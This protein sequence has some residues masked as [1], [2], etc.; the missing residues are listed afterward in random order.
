[1]DT[2]IVC[3]VLLVFIT[4]CTVVK[5]ALLVKHLTLYEENGLL[6]TEFNVDEIFFTHTIHS[7][8]SH[9]SWKTWKNDNSFSSPGKILEF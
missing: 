1:M 4:L 3:T 5:I 7:Q 8:G 6:A 9:S 2:V